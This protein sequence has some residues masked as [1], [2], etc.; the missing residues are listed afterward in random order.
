MQQLS[1]GET[2]DACGEAFYYQPATA[3]FHDIKVY[4]QH[5]DLF[6][7]IAR[8]APPKVNDIVIKISEIGLDLNSK[9]MNK[10]DAQVTP[11]KSND[12]LRHVATQNAP[13]EQVSHLPASNA[14]L[15]QPLRSA[16]L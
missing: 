5:V 10:Q 12:E 13:C 9:D 4:A 2:L 7:I 14:H 8:I 15:A 3:L 16:G 1:L 11:S 6:L